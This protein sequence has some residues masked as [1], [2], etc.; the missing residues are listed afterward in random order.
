MAFFGG[1]G[2]RGPGFGG[3]TGGA[4]TGGGVAF[5]TEGAG[6][7]SGGFGA[8]E[9]IRALGGPGSD[10]EIPKTTPGAGF[11]P[12]LPLKDNIR[13]LWFELVL[14]DKGPNLLPFIEPPKP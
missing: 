2:G 12:K 5:W 1:G 3:G 14:K 9:S 6:G 4:G 8:A 10:S 7:G 11:S 13:P